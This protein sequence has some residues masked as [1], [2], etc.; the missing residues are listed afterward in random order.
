MYIRLCLLTVTG[1]RT[2]LA[3]DRWTVFRVDGTIRNFP[4]HASRAGYMPRAFRFQ[5]QPMTKPSYGRQSVD[6]SRCD[7]IKRGRHA[8][9]ATARLRNRVGQILETTRLPCVSC[10]KIDTEQLYK[11]VTY[12]YDANFTRL[13]RGYFA[14][15]RGMIDVCLLDFY[16]LCLC[17]GNWVGAAIWTTTNDKCL[18]RKLRFYIDKDTRLL[19]NDS[20][21]Y[22]FIILTTGESPLHIKKKVKV[23]LL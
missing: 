2:R 7:V 12:I 14:C 1:G 11:E 4:A 22:T 21:Y 13:L 17:T 18:K 16:L 19:A 23:D 15:A 20:R 6:R 9:T 10:I 5:V 3:C 8:C